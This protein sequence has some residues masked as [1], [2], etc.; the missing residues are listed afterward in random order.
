MVPE[1]KGVGLQ[2]PKGS[3]LDL[4]GPRGSKGRPTKFD[5]V[6]TFDWGVPLTPQSFHWLNPFSNH[7]HT[8]VA[9]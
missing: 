3:G 7:L 2:G 4:Q 6:I 5:S 1:L 9:N 8:L